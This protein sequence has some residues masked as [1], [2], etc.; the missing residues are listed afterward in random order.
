MSYTV[1]QPGR[2]PLPIINFPSKVQLDRLAYVYHSHPDLAKFEVFAKDFGFIEES[3]AN[4]TIYYRGYGKD[5]CSYV[6][7]KSTDGEKRF[8]GAAYVAKTEQDFLKAASLPG[9]SPVEENAGPYGGKRVSLAS[10]SGTKIHVLWGVRE[11]PAPEKV[12]SAT[13]IQKGATNTALE[14]HRKGESPVTGL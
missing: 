9:A 8:D 1:A 7:A 11:R 4:D 2:I 6:A 14:K 12:L 10:P 5:L 13:E 3:R